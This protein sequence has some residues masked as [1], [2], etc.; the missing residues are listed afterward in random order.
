MN[1]LTSTV[2]V[3]KWNKADGSL[4]FVTRI[5]LLPRLSHAKSTGCDTVISKDGKN[6]YFANR[7][8]DFI[9][10]F[11]ADPQTGTLTALGRTAS[12]GTTPR[13]FVL[14]PTERW[15]LVANQDSD[16]LTVFTRDPQTGALADEGKSYPCPAPM[17][18]LFA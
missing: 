7:G 15:M 13:N 11:T 8:D 18:I 12:G 2:D 16:Q 1:E 9:A 5:K 14:D 4:A 6:V 17:C 3:L 10:S